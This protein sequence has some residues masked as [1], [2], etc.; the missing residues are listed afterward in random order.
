MACEQAENLGLFPPRDPFE[1]V[2]MSAELRQ[3][4][5]GLTHGA[6]QVAR[7]ERAF[8]LLTQVQLLALPPQAQSGACL[9]SAQNPSTYRM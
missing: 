9:R 7:A 5:Y 3:P 2:G 1:W 8:S 4:F 6:G